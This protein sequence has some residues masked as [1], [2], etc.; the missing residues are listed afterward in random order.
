[1]KKRLIAAAA[2]AAFAATATF[3]QTGS[4]TDLPQP[5]DAEERP[6]E[7]TYH[8][9]TV[10]D[11]YHWLR[12]QSY[13]VVDDADVLDY[14]KAEN[15]YFEAVMAPHQ[16]LIDELFEEL[17]ARVKED[18]ASVPQKNGDYEYWWAFE[19][20]G[21]YRK[22]YRR[23]VAGPESASG[24]G[25][26]SASGAGG[27]AEIILD[28][29]A[30]AEGEEYFKLGTISVSPDGRLLAYSTDTNGSER[31]TLRVKNLET[32]EILPDRIE[33]LFSVVWGDDSE[34]F[35]YTIADE[36][37]RS[38]VVLHHRLGADPAQDREL[39]REEDEE[40]SVSIGRSQSRDHAILSTGTNTTS[41]VRIL[42]TN[43]L[44][45]AP[46]LV[47]AREEGREYDVDEMGGRLYI[48]VNDTHPNFRVVTAPVTAP[49]EWAEYIPGTDS[50]YIRGVTPFENIITVEE[51]IAGLDQVRLIEP[52]G[53]SQNYIRFP[54][55]SYTAGLGNNPEPRMEK[56][57]L[58]YESMVTPDTV[59]D[60]DLASGE[61]EVLK[62]EEIPSGYDA[63]QYT[64]ER[65]EIEAR[66]GTMVP[67]SI[68]YR[69][70]FPKDG[71][72]P[73]HLYAYGAY[74]YAVPPGF[75]ASR[76]SL[77]DR[78]YAFAIAHIRGGDDLGYQWYL[79]GKLEKRTN[80]ST[81]SSMSRA[82]WWSA[83]IPPRAGSSRPAAPPA[84]S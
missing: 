78:G 80:T 19:E 24:A 74:G 47:S 54:E 84:A 17:K 7:F 71:S 60:Y 14:L 16:P 15:S 27:E 25:A 35:L 18:D 36:K 67:V 29:P 8:G 6:H 69:K 50:N 5:P 38:K 20:G 73:L 57:R 53:G 43:D 4:M 70:G 76:L 23:P 3:A 21:Q 37:W 77:I 81:T 48:R 2:A 10:D 13:P 68:V 52:E 51:R 31:Y 83:A 65:L 46:V 12:D 64:S 61:L 45:A 56:L 55:P 34:S 22:W 63:D 79:D 32:G 33:N 42:P 1:M 41:E 9:V 72:R 26:G 49:G 59:Y 58:G 39:Y 44:T 62:V 40:F 66:D 82:G 28:E 30:L 75:A 11:P